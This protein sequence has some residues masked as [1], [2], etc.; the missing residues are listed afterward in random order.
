MENYNEN[1]VNYPVVVSTMTDLAR[2]LIKALADERV[3]QCSQVLTAELA[4]F[5]A[6]MCRALRQPVETEL[7]RLDQVINAQLAGEEEVGRRCATLREFMAAI[8]EQQRT[9]GYEHLNETSV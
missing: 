7:R 3:A 1:A 5:D 2:R 9:L 6:K 4:K 8:E